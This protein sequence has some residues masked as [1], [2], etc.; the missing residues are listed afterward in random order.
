MSPIEQILIDTTIIPTKCTVFT[1]DV[2]YCLVMQSC[3][4]NDHTCL[5]NNQ[6]SSMN[7]LIS[8]HAAESGPSTPG[9]EQAGCLDLI[10]RQ[11]CSGRLKS[12]S[13]G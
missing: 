6:E 8:L 7:Q 10:E 4:Q 11:R 13:I 5:A 2:N 9:L 3:Q 12:V 1:I